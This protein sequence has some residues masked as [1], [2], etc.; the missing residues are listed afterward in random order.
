MKKKRE[1]LEKTWS[2][3]AAIADPSWKCWPLMR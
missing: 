2:G 1:K 3:A